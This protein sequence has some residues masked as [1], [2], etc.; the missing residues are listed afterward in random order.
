MHGDEGYVGAKIYPGATSGTK[1]VI[2]P[3]T[4][5]G[6]LYGQDVKL[7]GLDVYWQCS[8]SDLM[9]IDSIRL[10]R[11]IDA[12]SYADI[13]FDGT[14]RVCYVGAYPDGCTIHMD[15]TTN[16]VLSANSGI[17]HLAI[18]LNFA[19]ETTWNRILGVRLTLEYQE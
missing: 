13:G 4:I 19:G 1:Y 5:T 17:L 3:V 16:N 10:R 2:M 14:D 7:T 6:T 15:L 11:T 8:G 12:N 18:G 9:G